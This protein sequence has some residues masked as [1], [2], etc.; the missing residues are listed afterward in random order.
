[1]AL[2][3][4]KVEGR[5]RPLPVRQLRR[6]V[7]VA[8]LAEQSSS[9]GGKKLLDGAPPP[10]KYELVTLTIPVDKKRHFGLGA[11]PSDSSPR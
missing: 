5:S 8:A 10:K 7:D 2:P 4:G 11:T 9:K 3:C 1:M 6:S